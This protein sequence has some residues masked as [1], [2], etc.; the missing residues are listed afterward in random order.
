MFAAN[1]R[2]IKKNGGE[3]CKHKWSFKPK[4]SSI[5]HFWLVNDGWLSHLLY[6]KLVNGFLLKQWKPA[7]EHCVETKS[8]N[9]WNFC[10]QC[11]Y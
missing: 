5:F 2:D 10:R 1:S 6:V 4:I 7:R 3:C 8:L 11:T 9:A